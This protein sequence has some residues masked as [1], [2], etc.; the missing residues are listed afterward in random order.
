MSIGLAI[1]KVA[2]YTD[3]H[4]DAL[5]KVNQA[6]LELEMTV[7]KGAEGRQSSVYRQAMEQLTKYKTLAGLYKDFLDFWN[8]VIKSVMEMLKKAGELAVGSR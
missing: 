2:E 5:E 8:N 4:A 6:E 7:S 3:K 1:A